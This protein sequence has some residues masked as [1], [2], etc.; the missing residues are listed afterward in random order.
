[1]FNAFVIFVVAFETATIISFKFS[2]VDIE[3][4][5]INGWGSSSCYSQIIN[6]TELI[7]VGLFSNK[8]Q[9]R[10]KTL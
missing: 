6:L 7:E 9:P 5:I 3:S 1:M 4:P 8:H 10:L 2:W